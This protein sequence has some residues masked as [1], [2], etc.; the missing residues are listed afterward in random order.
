MEIVISILAKHLL[1]LSAYNKS[2]PYKYVPGITNVGKESNLTIGEA[3]KLIEDV[4][5]NL[6]GE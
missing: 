2:L 4:I 3:I 5:E 6:K 1:D